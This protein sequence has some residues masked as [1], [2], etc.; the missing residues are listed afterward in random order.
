VRL[1]QDGS[2]HSPTHGI[3]YCLKKADDINIVPF[4]FICVT[5]FNVR[6]CFPSSINESKAIGPDKIGPKVLNNCADALTASLY[7]LFSLSL[8]EDVVPG[9]WICLSLKRNKFC[10]IL[11]KLIYWPLTISEWNIYGKRTFF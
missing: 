2:I 9:D 6:T 1:Q 7:H 11:N 4:F 8:I 10:Y 5:V 3:Y